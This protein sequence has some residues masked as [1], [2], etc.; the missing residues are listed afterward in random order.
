M[1]EASANA[2]SRLS[3]KR[4]R[5]R[6]RGT[7]RK[8]LSGSPIRTIRSR[9]GLTQAEFAELIG[10]SRRTLENWEQGRR[11]P[12]GPTRAFLLLV[13]ADPDVV[14]S[15]NWRRRLGAARSRTRG[16]GRRRRQ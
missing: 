3:V 1:L 14:S 7:P 2:R 10:V 8:V 13:D 5:V 9:L 12:T 4:G 11:E 16:G 15:S 6:V